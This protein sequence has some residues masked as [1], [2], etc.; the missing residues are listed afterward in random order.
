MALQFQ[1]TDLSAW[2]AM[3]GHGPY[4]WACY[5][6]GFLCLL[7]LALSP[8]RARRALLA[9]LRQ[10]QRIEAHERQQAQTVSPQGR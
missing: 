6:I 8:L 7:F 4:V 9:D 1:F 3:G 2:L 10:A 5:G